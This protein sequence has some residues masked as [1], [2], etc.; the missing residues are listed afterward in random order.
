MLDLLLLALPFAFL[1]LAYRP[2]VQAP[3]ESEPFEW[4]PFAI[5]AI[6]KNLNEG[7]DVMVLVKSVYGGFS[8]E[9]YKSF[10]RHSELKRL[11]EQ[12]SLIPMEMDFAYVTKAPPG[13]EAEY[14]WVLQQDARIKST[15]SVL[16]LKD[17]SKKTYPMNHKPET[18]RNDLRKW[19]WPRTYFVIAIS[20]FLTLIGR[21][22]V[23]YNRLPANA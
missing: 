6:D 4:Q 8:K 3:L 15:F 7:R 18:V 13:L 21:R 10:S 11:V 19:N 12:G 2:V 17:G 23:G 9:W 22:V 20:L 5:G 1:G 16:Y 14:E